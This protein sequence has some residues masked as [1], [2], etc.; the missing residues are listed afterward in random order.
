M[1]A[2]AAGMTELG[3]KED[4]SKPWRD[5]GQRVDSVLLEACIT[6]R[7]AELLV[8]GYTILGG[9]A[10]PTFSFGPIW[11]ADWMRGGFRQME[12]SGLG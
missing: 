6:D 11:K 3:S 4:G 12:T 8:G 7:Q 1:I 2:T 10:D 5:V 9:F